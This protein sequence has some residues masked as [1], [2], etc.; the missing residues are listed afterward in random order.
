MFLDEKIEKIENVEKT[1]ADIMYQEYLANKDKYSKVDAHRKLREI[2]NEYE[3]EW[4]KGLIS[5]TYLE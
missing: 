3:N 2:E 1:N 5:K 4:R